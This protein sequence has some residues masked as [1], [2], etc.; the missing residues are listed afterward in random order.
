M[1]ILLA[2]YKLVNHLIIFF[3]GGKYKVINVS[4]NCTLPKGY[5]VLQKRDDVDFSLV[6]HRIAIVDPDYNK[7]WGNAEY[8]QDYLSEERKKFYELIVKYITESSIKLNQ[9]SCVLDVGMGTGDFLDCLYKTYLRIGIKLKMYGVDRSEES[10]KI[11]AQKVPNLDFSISNIHNLPFQSNFFECVTC[12]EVLEH[13][14]FVEKA[15][16]ELVRITKKS[17]LIVISIPNGE[18]D[19]WL[20]HLNFWSKQSFLEM[21]LKLNVRLCKF[22]AIDKNSGFMFIFQK[23]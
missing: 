4:K 12:L 7:H 5:F 11:A 6:E 20:G 16:S 21:A 9:E 23:I 18:K 3:S 1:K 2:I 17:G 19:D 13:I 8:L 15:F 10:I 22:A 14:Q